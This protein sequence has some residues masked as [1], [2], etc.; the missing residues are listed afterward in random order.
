MADLRDSLKENKLWPVESR[1]RGAMLST[2]LV[3][4]A[5]YLIYDGFK[6][7]TGQRQFENANKVLQ[8]IKQVV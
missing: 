8:V 1:K 6:C 4:A 2:V 7:S 5:A 3:G